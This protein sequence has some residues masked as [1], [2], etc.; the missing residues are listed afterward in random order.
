MLTRNL[1]IAGFLAIVTVISIS[2]YLSKED[3]EAFRE[4]F[5]ARDPKPVIQ[6]SQPQLPEGTV[7]PE[8]TA[9]L[10]QALM[11]AFRD[12]HPAPS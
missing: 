6:A 7:M 8:D 12:R 11:L 3:R 4:A 10:S 1:T 9:K 5:R 2:A